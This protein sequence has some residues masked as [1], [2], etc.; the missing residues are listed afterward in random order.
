VTYVDDEKM[1]NLIHS[2]GNEKRAKAES[3]LDE[4]MEARRKLTTN[5]KNF[6]RWEQYEQSVEHKEA[7][8]LEF[9]RTRPLNQKHISLFG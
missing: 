7:I 1:M 2:L 5:L 9:L 8:V 6:F 3:L 4:R